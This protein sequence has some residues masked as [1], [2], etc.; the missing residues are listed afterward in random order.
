[1]ARWGSGA[2]GGGVGP[3]VR[4]GV[5]PPPGCRR[6]RRDRRASVTEPGP[7]PFND[8]KPQHQALRAELLA[9]AERV[10][11]RGWF[12]L[13]AE[14]EAFEREFATRCGSAH[15]VGVASGTEALQL[16][17]TALGV[18]PGDEVLTVANTAVP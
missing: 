18:E 2:A 7:I 8:L 17:L 13:G 6:P 15:G 1:A 11:D 14:L 9:A 3:P 10:V 5:P 4:S 12:L 16:A